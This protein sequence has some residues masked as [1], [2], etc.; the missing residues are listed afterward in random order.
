MAKFDD[1]KVGDKI[2]RLLGGEVPMK[3]VVGKIE[4]GIIYTSSE[5]GIVPLKHGWKFNQANGAEIDE[6]LGWDGI[7]IT[8][9][10]LIKD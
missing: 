10:Y 3:V 5:D 6:D 4:N 1:V 8:G 7:T 9:S 2:T